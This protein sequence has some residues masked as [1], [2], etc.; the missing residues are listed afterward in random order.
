[1][2]SNS[3]DIDK[4]EKQAKESDKTSS[5]SISV[6]MDVLKN[7][8]DWKQRKATIK[9]LTSLED[10]RSIGALIQA[11]QDKNFDV[12]LEAVN[13]LLLVG[14]ELIEPLT[15]AL[16]SNDV[17]FRT[18]AAWTLGAINDSRAINPLLMAMQDQNQRVRKTACLALSKYGRGAVQPLINHLKMVESFSIRDLRD[19]LLLSSRIFSAQEDWVHL[20]ET[21]AYLIDYH[22]LTRGQFF[23]VVLKQTAK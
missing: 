15:Q 12:R 20:T 3:I 7:H 6:L 16:A 23:R 9:T 4:R 13:G 21:L 10:H 2:L 1:M 11:L 18:T 14:I 17:E 8:P 19:I 22:N 5:G